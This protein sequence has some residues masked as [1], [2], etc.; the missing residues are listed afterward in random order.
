MLREEAKQWLV[1]HAYFGS[2]KT[3]NE[4]LD[5]NGQDSLD[6][7]YFLKVQESYITESK[8][9]DVFFK[10]PSEDSF[11]E[12]F[13]K[14]MFDTARSNAVVKIEKEKNNMTAK[15]CDKCGALYDEGNATDGVRV[16]FKTEEVSDY[17]KDMY[18]DKRLHDMHTHEV[19]LKQ[20][21][22]K[23]DLCPECRESFRKWWEEA[24]DR[25]SYVEKKAE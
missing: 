8:D 25:I 12:Y 16:F 9:Q 21:G 20:M 17:D 23:I 1:N 24:N 15:K 5:K 11:I 13:R 22:D 19:I 7:L 3:I 18:S 10:I 2:L 14:H 6:S 4:Y